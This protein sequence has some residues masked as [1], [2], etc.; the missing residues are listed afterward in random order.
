MVGNAEAIMTNKME[1]INFEVTTR[2]PLKCP[3]CYCSLTEGKHL[4]IAVAKKK[5]EEAALHGVKVAH[6]SGGETLC[7]PSQIRAVMLLNRK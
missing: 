7:Y 5:I 2:C 6:V 3:Q 4:N 1:G